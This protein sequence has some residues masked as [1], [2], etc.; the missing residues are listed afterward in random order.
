[1][2]AGPLR[3]PALPDLAALVWRASRYREGT[4]PAGAPAWTL[5]ELSGRLAELSGLGAAAQLTLAFLLVRE[6]QALG[7]PAAWVSHR[8]S[9]FYPPD[10]AASGVDLSALP[11]IFVGDAQEAARAAA[12]LARSGA[13]GLLVVDLIGIDPAVPPALQSRLAGLARTHDIAVLILTEKPADAPSVGSLVSFRGEALR[14][15]VEGPAESVPEEGAARF[16]CRLRV[17]KDKRRGPGWRHE[18][19]CRGPAGLR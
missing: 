5:D 14:R 17:L 4:R 15:R 9:S 10:A 2:A 6:A 19:L 16:A 7:E 3:D 1:M 18:E 12:Q 11:V 8:R 13:F